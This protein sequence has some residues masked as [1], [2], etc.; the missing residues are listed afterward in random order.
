MLLYPLVGHVPIFNDVEKMDQL[1]IKYGL[2]TSGD[3]VLTLNSLNV[4][5]LL[6]PRQ[7]WLRDAVDV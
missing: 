3:S 6:P 4:V 5:P 1:A 7:A 2:R